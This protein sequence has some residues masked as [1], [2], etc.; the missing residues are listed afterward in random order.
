MTNDEVEDVAGILVGYERWRKKQVRLYDSG[1]DP[2]SVSSYLDHLA[3]I[4]QGEAIEELKGLFGASE[5]SF[6][7]T[8]DQVFSRARAILGVEE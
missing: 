8:A 5:A 1:F 6:D 4:R 3:H 2:L 7:L